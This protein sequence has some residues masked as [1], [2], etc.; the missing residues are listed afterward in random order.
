MGIVFQGQELVQEIH[1]YCRA[2]RAI[3]MM[4][5][6]TSITIVHF[7][8]P[9]VLFILWLEA[10]IYFKRERYGGL[11]YVLLVMEDLWNGDYHTGFL[12]FLSLFIIQVLS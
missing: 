7:V 9:R 8:Q 1:G 11:C 10:I 5:S 6:C 12:L 4:C 2:G 3:P